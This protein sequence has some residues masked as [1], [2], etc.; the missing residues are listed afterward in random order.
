MPWHLQ[1][2]SHPCHVARCLI[3]FLEPVRYLHGTDDGPVHTALLWGPTSSRPWRLALLC[4]TVAAALT[5]TST[6][7]IILSAPSTVLVSTVAALLR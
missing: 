3:Y 6:M 4:A 5:V 1:P 7:A 2:S